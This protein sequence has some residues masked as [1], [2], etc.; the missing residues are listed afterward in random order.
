MAVII[1]EADVESK[2]RVVTLRKGPNLTLS[3][4]DRTSST[5]ITVTV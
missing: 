1:P 3:P 5:S 2:E 4:I